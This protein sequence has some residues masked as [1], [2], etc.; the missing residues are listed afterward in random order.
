MVE[1]KNVGRLRSGTS[2]RV[3]DSQPLGEVQAQPVDVDSRGL[4]QPVS[5]VVI[6][7]K[8]SEPENK[9]SV[10]SE[11]GNQSSSDG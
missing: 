11:P 1:N 10:P 7:E 6:D 9:I 4:S 5:E 8:V 2:F 3:R